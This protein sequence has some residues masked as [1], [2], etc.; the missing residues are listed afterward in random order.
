VTDAELERRDR[1][2]RRF[3]TA[4]VADRRRAEGALERAYPQAIALEPVRALRV[5]L[6]E[7]GR[8]LHSEAAGRVA[9]DP[10]RAAL[11]R[12]L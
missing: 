7:C 8:Q 3:A 6:R 4:V 10:R 12:V 9:P 11:D 2:L 5:V 1:R